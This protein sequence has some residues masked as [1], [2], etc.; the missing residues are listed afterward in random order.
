MEFEWSRQ[1]S[2][3][4]VADGAIIFDGPHYFEE[5]STK[6]A[7]REQRRIAIGM[8]TGEFTAVIYTDRVGTDRRRIIPA[9]NVR[10]NERA[11]YDQGKAPA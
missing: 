10:K 11:K 9:R 5:D 1:K 3:H 6:S 2:R 8:V 4:Y 7:F